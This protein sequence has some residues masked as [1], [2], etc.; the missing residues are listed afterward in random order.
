M[1]EVESNWFISGNNP[2]WIVDLLTK[3]VVVLNKNKLFINVVLKFL[4][5]HEVVYAS[6]SIE[7]LLLSMQLTKLVFQ[8]IFAYIS[9]GGAVS[10]HG[11]CI[12]KYFRHI[13]KQIVKGIVI[14]VL[15]NVFACFECQTYWILFWKFLFF[16][17]IIS[18]SIFYFYY[19]S[20]YYGI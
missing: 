5:L 15:Q 20:V 17:E 7:G 4:A 1:N 2:F 9:T 16:L 18:I 12:F 14:N 11:A 10:W 8:T 13:N 19:S 3:W 6:A